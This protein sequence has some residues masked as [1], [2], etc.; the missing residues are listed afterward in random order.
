MTFKDLFNSSKAI[1]QQRFNSEKNAQSE[2]P[3][4]LEDHL[5][6]S[7]MDNLQPKKESLFAKLS[8][9][10]NHYR[11]VS[12]LLFTKRNVYIF[13]AFADLGILAVIVF[14]AATPASQLINPLLNPNDNLQPLTKEQ[15]KKGHEVFGFAPHWTFNRLDN[16]DFDVLTT[17]AY[18]GVD[19]DGQGNLD[20]AGR[21]YQ[22]FKSDQATQVFQKA[23]SKGTKV[24][25][26]ITQ[27]KNAPIKELMDNEEAQQNAINQI[28]AEVRDRGIDGVNID[29][30]YTGNPGDGYRAKF[31]KFMANLNE[32]MDREL[33]GSQITVS[34]YASAVKEPKI[35]DIKA[36]GQTVDGVF[37]MAYDFAV[38]GSANAI[39]TAPLYGH[40][41][42][43]YW[44]DISTA[45]EEFTAVMP[46]EKLILGVP[47]YGYNYAVQSPT[48]KTATSKGYTTYYKKGRRTYSQ[49]VPYK[50]YAQ[51][52]SIVTND[53]TEKTEGITNYT[54]GFDEYGKVSWKAY[55]VPSAGT[56]RMVFIDDVKSLSHKYDFA[57][58][59]GL[60]G[61]GMW[62]LGFDNGK[63]EMWTLLKEKFGAKAYADSSI[64]ERTIN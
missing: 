18:F 38:A 24:V 7:C 42:G 29:M 34:V 48:V 43:K 64:V 45:V 63:T 5:L 51:T 9:Q 8:D 61:V 28:I 56:W 22:V 6:P 23:H 27:M 37:M 39:P 14:Y 2:L 20:K 4:S 54:E 50:N 10:I 55:Y 11:E 47:W 16:V 62:A 13:A 60:G 30:E 59:K 17:F 36:L 35:Y 31:S 32:Q 57:K 46:A 49:F 41:E 25:L 12:K 58:E 1:L 15:E 3:I 26:T 33:P 52:Y 44:Y 21:G 19:L 40:K 53:V